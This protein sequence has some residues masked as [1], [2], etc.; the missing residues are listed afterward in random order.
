MSV[1][2]HDSITHL[3]VPIDQVEQH[4]DNPNNGDAEVVAESILGNGFYNPVIVQESTGFIVAGNTRYAALLSLGATEIPVVWAKLTNE[5]AIRILIADNRTAELAVR[6]NNEVEALLKAL[7]ATDEGLAG[8]GFSEQ[9]FAELKH[10]NRVS[11]HAEFGGMEEVEEFDGGVQPYIIIRGRY[12]E[13]L[14]RNVSF[15]RT[16]A[17]V[18]AVQL[19]EMGY[20]ASAGGFG[21]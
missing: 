2:F 7:E 5:Q 18:Q 8:T 14:G 15:D 1:R 16:E 20:D 4:P 9:D 10:M 19:V 12:D 3:L 17:Q 13:D 6:D 21:G 11:S